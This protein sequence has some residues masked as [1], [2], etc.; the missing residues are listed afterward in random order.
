LRGLPKLNEIAG[1]RANHGPEFTVFLI[2]KPDLP[3]SMADMIPRLLLVMAAA[4]VTLAST[5]CCCLF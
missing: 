4:I 1:I 3:S 5:S 2:A